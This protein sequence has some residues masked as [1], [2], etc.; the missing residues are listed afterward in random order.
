MHIIQRYDSAAAKS[1]ELFSLQSAKLVSTIATILLV[2]QTV[3][4]GGS[5]FAEEEHQVWYYFSTSLLILSA[6]LISL[7]CPSWT[8]KRTGLRN[9]AV[10][11]LL[12]RV[13]LR[14]LHQTGSKWIHLEDLSDWLMR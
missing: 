4:L 12:D 14:R 3:S 5:S 13:F 11:L 2:L 10:L 6:G 7:S 9:L 8:P 1:V